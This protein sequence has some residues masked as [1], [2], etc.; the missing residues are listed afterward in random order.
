MFQKLELFLSSGEK[1]ERHLLNLGPVIEIATHNRPRGAFPLFHLKMEMM[2]SFRI[3]TDG[4]S[5]ETVILKEDLP[6][7]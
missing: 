6:S 4:Q 7:L 3:L 5:S 2:C 1:R